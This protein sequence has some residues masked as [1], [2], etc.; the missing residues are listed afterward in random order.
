MGWNLCTQKPYGGRVRV[1]DP[2]QRSV[3]LSK[4]RNKFSAVFDDDDMAADVD[5]DIEQNRS[6]DDKVEQEKKQETQSNSFGPPPGFTFANNVSN[7]YVLW[8]W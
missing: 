8:E 7:T 1:R 5:V 6:F 3:P 2:G 4:G